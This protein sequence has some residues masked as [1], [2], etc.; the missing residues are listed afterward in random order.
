MMSF[1]PELSV[2]E[3][4]QEGRLNWYLKHAQEG[5]PVAQ[6]NLGVCY[7]NGL[8][9]QKDESLA[10][11]WYL[12]SAEQGYA[13]AQYSTGLCYEQ[14]IGVEKDMEQALSWYLKA[15]NQ[16][17]MIAQY[18]IELARQDDAS[19]DVKNTEEAEHLKAGFIE[20]LSHDNS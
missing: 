1:E 3:T 16:G 6:Y 9:I 4:A 18:A 19:C 10:F 5:H 12:K 2:E 8:N 15:A 14:G 17:H 20:L 7:K 11:F 13:M